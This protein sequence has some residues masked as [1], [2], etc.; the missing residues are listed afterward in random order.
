MSCPSL[1]IPHSD[2]EAKIRSRISKGKELLELPI[3]SQ[4][5]FDFANTEQKK[6]D[7]YN[8]ELLKRIVDTDDLL[9]NY[10][11]PSEATSSNYN[12]TLADSH[13]QFI[14][15]L[16]Y[17]I[18][19]LEAI[20]ERLELIPEASVSIPEQSAYPK[21]SSKSPNLWQRK[22]LYQTLCDDFNEND[23]TTLC[24]HLGIDYET[25]PTVGKDN[26]A[27]EL[28]SLVERTNRISE[29]IEEGKEMRPNSKWEL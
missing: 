10:D 25:L 26:K 16:K 8:R 17:Y 22:M 11:D 6:W 18:G 14:A 9:V 7:G 4:N 21:T 12:P 2:A 23:L 1:L 24:F 19:N 13:R 15:D 3:T 5:E 20:L 29:L 28:I 27:R